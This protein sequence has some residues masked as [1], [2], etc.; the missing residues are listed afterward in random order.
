VGVIVFVGVTVGVTLGVAVGVN[1]AGEDDP[2]VGVI[3]GVTV[4]VAVCVAVGVCVG[5]FV[6]VGVKL[7]LGVDVTVG[8]IVVVLVGVIVDVGVIV[9]VGVGETI[10]FV[11][12][13]LKNHNDSTSDVLTT[14][15]TLLSNNVE[16]VTVIS[17]YPVPLYVTVGVELVS[18]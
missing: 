3:E 17:P 13:K 9:W 5:V 14:I 7:E 10:T 2:N 6:G 16:P 12:Y 1:V 8:V 15:F 11:Q 4:E 18:G